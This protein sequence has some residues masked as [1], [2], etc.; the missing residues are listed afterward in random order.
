[1]GALS[2]MKVRREERKKLDVGPL[3]GRADLN[4][5]STEPVGRVECENARKAEGAQL[6]AGAR[7]PAAAVGRRVEDAKTR[8]MVLVV[9][10][11]EQE[12]ER[13]QAGA[14]SAFK[15]PPAA[16]TKPTGTSGPDL[17]PSSLFEKTLGWAV[18]I[19]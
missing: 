5:E 2:V 19:L 15:Q 11:G 7:S 9:E 3:D 10:D 17:L 4:A 6:A 8:S 12:S 1:M 18:R 16:M 14:A 13:V